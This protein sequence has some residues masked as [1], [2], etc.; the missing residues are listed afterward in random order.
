MIPVADTL[1]ETK[2]KRFKA[3]TL[4][5][6]NGNYLITNVPTVRALPLAVAPTSSSTDCNYSMFFSSATAKWYIHC[7]AF[8]TGNAVGDATIDCYIYY[9]DY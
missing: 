3:T 1:M 4:N 9:L 2:L 7:S 5:Q 8:A 6:G